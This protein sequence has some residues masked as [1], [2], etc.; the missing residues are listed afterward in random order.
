MMAEALDARIHSEL[1]ELQQFGDLGADD[2]V[3][4]PY[5]DLDGAA[6]MADLK[7]SDFPEENNANGPTSSTMLAAPPDEGTV[8][9]DDGHA[10]RTST[11]T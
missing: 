6:Y 4:D 5:H 7:S 10:Q 9:E 2:T 11:Y 3:E 1:A 8:H